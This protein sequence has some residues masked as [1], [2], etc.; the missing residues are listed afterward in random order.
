MKHIKTVKT[1]SGP[2]LETWE[3]AD[4]YIAQGFIYAIKASVAVSNNRGDFTEQIYEKLNNKYNPI[5]MSLGGIEC[6]YIEVAKEEL[7]ALLHQIE[8]M[9]KSDLTKGK[10]Y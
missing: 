8:I 10:V 9:D 6:A 4:G 5:K 2:P 1:Y 3:L 7:E